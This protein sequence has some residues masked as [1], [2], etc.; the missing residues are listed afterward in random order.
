MK[1]RIDMTSGVPAYRQIVDGLRVLLVSGQLKPGTALPSVRRMALDL[2]VHFNTVAE[3]YRCLADEGWL[4][5]KHGRS[6]LV[7][8][9]TTPP[10]DNKKLRELAQ[11]LRALAA[12]MRAH[13][14]PLNRIRAELLA[15]AEEILS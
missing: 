11:Q 13:G 9:R 4:E 14:V 2:G 1:L 6:A 15:V 12:Q 10:A 5:L 3:A 7:I 8:E